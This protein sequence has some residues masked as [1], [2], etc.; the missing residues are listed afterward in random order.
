[1]PWRVSDSLN[2]LVTN[3]YGRRWFVVMCVQAVDRVLQTTIASAFNLLCCRFVEALLAAGR[4]TT[5]LAVQRARCATSSSSS[6]GTAAG[7]QQLS[8]REA[9]VL[10]RVQLGCGLLPEAFSEL[11]RHCSQVRVDLYYYLLHL[12]QLLHSQCM[13]SFRGFSPAIAFQIRSSKRRADG[14]S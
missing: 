4:P 3:L 11:R 12:L 1:M 13:L 8:L 6:S 7:L 14:F 10:L 2:C 5:A 9:Q